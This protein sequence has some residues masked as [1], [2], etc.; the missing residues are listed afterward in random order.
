MINK[1]KQNKIYKVLRYIFRHAFVRPIYLFNYARSYFDNDYVEKVKFYTSG[2]IKSLLIGSDN[3]QAK[4]II[5][6]GDGELHMHIGGNIDG[7]QKYSKRLARYYHKIITEYSS[8]TSP[9]VLAIPMFALES[10][11]VLRQKNLLSCWQPLK[12]SFR[13]YFNKKEMYA[14]AHIFYRDGNFDHMLRPILESHK[15][16][17]IAGRHNVELLESNKVK[18]HERLNI[19]FIQT[20]GV[21][22][23]NNFDDILKRF[24]V[25]IDCIKK[26][27]IS[28]GDFKKEYRILV[29]SGPTS[30]AIV[31]EL[32]KQG[33]ICYDIGKGVETMYQENKVQ[34]M[35]G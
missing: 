29:S 35:I 7:Y 25:L 22:D 1:I 3:I 34:Y 18:I 16:I 30:K 9:Y 6:L 27:S 28:E 5:R 19:K 2:E 4:S 8:V 32:S 12:A 26:D 23:F 24:F 10:N 20:D 17:M 11:A 21:E 33:Y 31:Y 13:T 15:L 14:D